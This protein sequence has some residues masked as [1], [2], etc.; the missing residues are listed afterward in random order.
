MANR[1][2]R[3]FALLGSAAL[4]G[5]ALQAVDTPPAH[6]FFVNGHWTAWEAPPTPEGAKVHI[7]VPGDTFWALAATD[8]GNPYLWPQIWNENKYIRDAHWIYPGDPIVLVPGG[9]TGWLSWIPHQERLAATRRAI[10]VQPVHNE[11][12]DS[13]STPNPCRTSPPRPQSTST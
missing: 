8:L 11:L 1:Q 3:I 2:L 13:P 10:R 12:H 7:V 5:A 9:L 6:L 4:A